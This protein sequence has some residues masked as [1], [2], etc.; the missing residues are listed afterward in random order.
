MKV[1]YKRENTPCLH[2]GFFQP[3]SLGKALLLG[4]KINWDVCALNFS[5]ALLKFS[6]AAA[7][8]FKW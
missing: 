6:F 7:S 3:S 1:Y 2:A 5:L 8:A 4:Y